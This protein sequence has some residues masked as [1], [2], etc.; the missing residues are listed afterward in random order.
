MDVTTCNHE[1]AKTVDD[2]GFSF[3]RG[4]TYCTPADVLS[5]TPDDGLGNIN[6][7]IGVVVSLGYEPTTLEISNPGN[8][9]W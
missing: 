2:I 5:V 7:T 1:N 8:D 3:C 4:G 9:A 6:Y